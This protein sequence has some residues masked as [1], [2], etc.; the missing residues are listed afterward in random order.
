MQGKSCSKLVLAAFLAVPLLAHATQYPLT[1]TDF[2]GQKVTIAHEPQ[3]VI[4]QDGRDIMA[5]ALLDRDDPFKRLVAWNNLA[6]KQDVATWEMLKTQ[7]P[8]A[9]SIMDMG[10]SDKGN[11]DLES[12]LSRQP[13]LMVAQLR[14]KPAL[15]DSGVLS[16]LAALHI[17]VLF[18]DYEVNPAKDTAA[19]VDLLGK[20]LN[21]ES[22]AAA[23]TTYYR[24]QLTA[25][26][27]K[28]ATIKP[29]AKVFVE[30]LAGNTD[31]CCFTHGHSGWGGLVEAI[32][33][34]NIGSELLPGASGFIALEKVISENPDVYIM[35]GSKRGNSQVLPLGLK[36]SPQ[37]VNAQAQVLLQRTGVGQ[38]PA[39]AAKHV[40]GVYHHFYNHPYNIVGMEYLA[41]DIYPQAFADLNPDATYHHII[42]NFT[43]LPD[44]NFVFSWQQSK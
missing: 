27:Q 40:Y 12:V 4:L 11:V 14:A 17:P 34:K 23:Y 31:A 5:M 25:I 33:A 15:A 19:S 44:D 10:F 22:N 41:K 35:T 6:K 38:I 42:K 8:E 3:R 13:D 2:S 26:E 20:V 28:T 16:K 36:T 21:R 9:T 32:G 37:E 24:Q 29:Q 7:W 39:V 18:I 1:V 30:A 43:K